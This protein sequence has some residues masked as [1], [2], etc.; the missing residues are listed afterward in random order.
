MKSYWIINHGILQG[1]CGKRKPL[2]NMIGASAFEEHLRK[3]LGGQLGAMRVHM[4]THRHTLEIWCECE[5]VT[6]FEPLAKENR[7]GDK[8]EHRDDSDIVVGYWYRQKCVRC[9]WIA[10]SQFDSGTQVQCMRCGCYT[11]DSGKFEKDKFAKRFGYGNTERVMQQIEHEFNREWNKTNPS[12]AYDFL[13]EIVD[14][15][16]QLKNKGSTGV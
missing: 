13:Q 8:T 15:T 2:N 6:E 4:D 1:S 9:G 10:R 14:A 11:R 3:A 5:Y 16:N 7:Y 12:N